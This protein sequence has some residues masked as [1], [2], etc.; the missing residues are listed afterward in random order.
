VDLP[1]NMRARLSLP[2]ASE[3]IAASG[4]GSPKLVGKEGERIVYELGSGH[5]ELIEQ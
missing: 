4:T 1:T 2:L 3:A 5:S